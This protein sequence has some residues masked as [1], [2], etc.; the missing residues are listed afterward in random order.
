MV[1]SIHPDPSKGSFGHLELISV[2]ILENQPIFAGSRVS[3][4][5]YRLCSSSEGSFGEDG[6][7][8]I[9]RRILRKRTY[10]E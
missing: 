6:V 10:S 9:V 4:P 1:F 7:G 8:S 3:D 5:L 2:G